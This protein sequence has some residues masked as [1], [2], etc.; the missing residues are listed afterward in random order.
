M[1]ANSYERPKFHSFM[2]WNFSF[3]VEDIFMMKQKFR[4]CLELN[5][6]QNYYGQKLSS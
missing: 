4:K 2:C 5:T 6:T 3:I 1:V